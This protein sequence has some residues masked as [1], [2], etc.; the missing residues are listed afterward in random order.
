MLP[1]NLREKL[2]G[3]HGESA[4]HCFAG[5]IDLIVDGGHDLDN[6]PELHRAL[7]DNQA[8]VWRYLQRDFNPETFTCTYVGVWR[9]FETFYNA[10]CVEFK[11]AEDRTNASV[12]WLD[13]QKTRVANIEAVDKMFCVSPYAEHRDRFAQIHQRLDELTEYV[14]HKFNC[15]KL[16]E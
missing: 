5:A 7:V 8:L 16:R 14:L 10:M 4:D 15:L 13:R 3:L 6:S 1:E 9:A 2:D 12:K 11:E